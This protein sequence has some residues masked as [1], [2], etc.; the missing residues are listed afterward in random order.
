LNF[1]TKPAEKLAAIG[2]FAAGTALAG[3]DLGAL[4]RVFRIF[5]NRALGFTRSIDR[6]TTE[7]KIM[8][9]PRFFASAGAADER[10]DKQTGNEVQKAHDFPMRK[11]G[12]PMDER[13]LV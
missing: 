8:G 1:L 11:N 13:T 3:P 7:A 4:S 9:F 10:E 2:W 12:H 5:P 6:R